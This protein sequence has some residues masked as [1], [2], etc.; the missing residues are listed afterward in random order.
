MEDGDMYD[1]LDIDEAVYMDDDDED[2]QFLYK[3]GIWSQ[4]AEISAEED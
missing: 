1:D 4:D 2:T 3:L